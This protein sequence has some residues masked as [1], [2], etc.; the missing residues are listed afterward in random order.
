MFLRRLSASSANNPR[1]RHS[2]PLPRNSPSRRNFFAHAQRR[3]PLARQRPRQIHSRH[4][5][6]LPPRRRSLRRVLQNDDAHVPLREAH[7]FHGS[8]RPHYAQ[9]QRPQAASLSLAALPRTLL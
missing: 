8:A 5:P 9:S 3:L 1:T 4:S 7:A 6:P 2:A